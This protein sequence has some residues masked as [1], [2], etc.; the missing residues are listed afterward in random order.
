MPES[1]NGFYELRVAGL[2]RRLKKVRVADTLVIASFVML[3]DTKLIEACADS[4][5]PLLPKDEIDMLV[6]PEAKGIPLTHA[7]AVRLGV[8]YIT[9]RKSVKRYMENPPVVEVQSITT[10][11][12]QLLVMDGVDRAKVEG[13]RI[14]VVDDVVSTG[15]SLRSVEKLLAEAGAEVVSKTAVLLEEGG[16]DGQDLIHLERLPVFPD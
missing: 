13:K 12:S 14:C 9:V 2:T 5:L 1:T 8:D 15:G 3:G 4:L 11:G 7:P 6:C 16:Y 10:A